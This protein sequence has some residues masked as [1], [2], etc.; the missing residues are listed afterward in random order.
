MENF[1]DPGPEEEPT[2]DQRIAVTR[3]QL[4]RLRADVL[5][6]QEVN[7]QEQYGA[8]AFVA[9]GQLI[10]GTTYE[11]FHRVSTTLV[12]EDVPLQE[13]NLVVL[14]R[15]PI[16]SHRQIKH[17]STPR[18]AYRRVTAAPS[19]PE[20]IEITWQRP[21]LLA[22]VTLPDGS[23]LHGLAL[24]LAM[25]Y[26]DQLDAKLLGAVLG[27]VGNLVTFRVGA[28]DGGILAREFAPVLSAEDL[29]SL[30]YH[31]IY[32]RMMIDGKPAR[33]FSAQVLSAQ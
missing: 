29:M 11:G 28:K 25:Q 12:G 5:C 10:A 26:L 19:D 24:V 14:S 7:S 22:G 33:A 31:H 20:A 21:I 27:N 32:V 9:L 8:R 4:E 1:G 15:F 16:A 17:E 18:P 23:T 13:R 2:L 3:P 30:P 6:L